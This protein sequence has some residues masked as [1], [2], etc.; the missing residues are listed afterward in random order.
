MAVNKAMAAQIVEALARGDKLSAIKLARQ[1]G[2]GSLKEA[3]TLVES[4]SGTDAQGIQLQIQKAVTAAKDVAGHH[5]QKSHAQAMHEAL[6][7]NNRKPTVV[8]GDTPGNLRWVMLVLGL[9]ALA[10]WMA[11]G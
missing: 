7:A 6:Q 11:M 2:V 3:V 1:A 5:G 8:S 4:M 9:V 10:A